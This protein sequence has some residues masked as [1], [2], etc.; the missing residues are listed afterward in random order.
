MEES[1]TSAQELHSSMEELR[2]NTQ[3]LCSSMK[4]LHSSTQRHAALYDALD[5]WYKG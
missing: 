1:H 4:E 5:V 2:A 3:E